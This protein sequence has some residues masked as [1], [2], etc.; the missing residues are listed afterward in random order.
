MVLRLHTST[1]SLLLIVHLQIVRK[2]LS[3]FSDCILLLVESPKHCSLSWIFALLLLLGFAIERIPSIEIVNVVSSSNITFSY[4]VDPQHVYRYIPSTTTKEFLIKKM[5]PINERNVSHQIFLDA[6]RIYGPNIPVLDVPEDNNDNIMLKHIL[7]YETIQNSPTIFKILSK[8]DGCYNPSI[9]PWK[10]RYLLACRSHDDRGGAVRLGWLDKRFQFIMKNQDASKLLTSQLQAFELHGEDYRLMELPN[11]RILLW[12]VFF[13]NN[14]AQ[15]Q[16]TEIQ[17]HSVDY[18]ITIGNIH[19][20]L[21]GKRTPPSTT[22]TTNYN[23][24][25]KDHQKNW[26]PFYD[27]EQ[28]QLYFMHSIIPMSTLQYSIFHYSTSTDSTTSNTSSHFIDNTNNIV[29]VKIM[30]ATNEFLSP[31][32]NITWMYGHVKGGTPA[33][34]INNDTYFGFFHSKQKLLPSNLITYLFGA[35]TFSAFPPYQLKA[36]SRA[37]LV[38]RE[39]YEGP[40]SHYK[41]YIDY[42][43]FPMTFVWK[44]PTGTTTTTTTSI[45]NNNNNNNDKSYEFDYRHC[46]VGIECYQKVNLVLSLGWQDLDG[47]LLEANLY[48]IL[49]TLVPSDDI[50]D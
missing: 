46:H 13:Q 42:I 27:H 15:I 22:S 4:Y 40:W 3:M 5:E 6:N 25:L 41:N 32:P 10:D 35:Y 29:T 1:Y 49:K 45:T 21:H 44:S 28:Q 37:P 31:L 30:E 12:F 36:F 9:A 43:L 39:L 24:L 34:R 38:R 20:H 2:T 11:N 16:V 14:I 33:R 50:V 19:Y 18:T 17:I 23:N 8:L 47:Y 7:L 48:D 26:C